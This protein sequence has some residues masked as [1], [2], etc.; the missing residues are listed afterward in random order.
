MASIRRVRDAVDVR[1]EPEWCCCA[2]A[3][4][5]RPLFGDVDGREEPLVHT[6]RAIHQSKDDAGLLASARRLEDARL[7][8]LHEVIGP[9]R[10]RKEHTWVLHQQVVE[11]TVAVG[12]A[13]V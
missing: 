3:D 7:D 1:R 13:K 10:G 4:D 8:A 5:E 11:R 9:L 12:E 6:G 2:L